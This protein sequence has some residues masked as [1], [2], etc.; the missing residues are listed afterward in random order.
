M[1]AITEILAALFLVSG[2][3]FVSVG[4]IGVLRMPDFYTRLHAS[5][6]CETLGIAL[7]LIGLAI[8]EGFTFTS[9]KLLLIVFFVFIANPIG[10]HI[11]TRAA[12][13]WK[14]KPWT[15]GEE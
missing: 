10:T 11:L 7:S 9:L 15:R 12:Y 5:S 6:K 2:F 13:R 14:V 1:D 3:F 8:Y 4:A